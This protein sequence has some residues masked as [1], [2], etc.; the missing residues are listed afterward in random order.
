MT[1]IIWR[2]GHRNIFIKHSSQSPTVLSCI[3]NI[4]HPHLWEDYT[5]NIH[6]ITLQSSTGHWRPAG[7][8]QGAGAEDGL[9]HCH[10]PLHEEPGWG[11]G[12]EYQ[13]GGRRVCGRRLRQD[14]GCT[15]LGRD[16]SSVQLQLRCTVRPVYTPLHTQPWSCPLQPDGDRDGWWSWRLPHTP[17]TQYW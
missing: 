7:H 3:V 6:H 12:A 13:T 5:I 14:R 4:V 2:R 8:H 15:A 1:S 16:P 11:L 10:C 17:H 9:A